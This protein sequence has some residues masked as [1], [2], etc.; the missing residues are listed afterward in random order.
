MMKQLQ[1]IS[2]T[3]ILSLCLLPVLGTAQQTGNPD[4]AR[5]TEQSP[6]SDK[7]TSPSKT[8]PARLNTALLSS[9][10]RE[11]IMKA[12]EGGML[13]VTL[14]QIAINKAVNPD[15]KQFA[16]RM[17]DD[18][19]K[20]NQELSALATSK[21]VTLPAADTKKEQ[22]MKEHFDKHAGA[23][24]DREY[25][26]QMVKDHKATVEMFERHSKSGRDADL[27]AFADKTLP[28]LREH[29]QLAQEIARKIGTTAAD[30]K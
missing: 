5:Q 13:E 21:G 12:A 3:L 22:K 15:V 7:K 28:T 14:G 24:F 1:T 27:K 4:K 11:F 2:L 18:H 10:D 20:A 23:D 9:S 29:H 19:S 25:M 16:Q 8:E 26:K 6:Q 30:A 17:V